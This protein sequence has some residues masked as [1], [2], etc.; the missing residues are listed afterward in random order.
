MDIVKKLDEKKVSSE[1]PHSTKTVALLS[2][3]LLII[4]II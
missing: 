4:A 3:S 2:L 1:F